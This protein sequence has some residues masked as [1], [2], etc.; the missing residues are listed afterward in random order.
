MIDL[1]GTPYGI[2]DDH[3]NFL[4]RTSDL[5]DR[6]NLLRGEGTLRPET[7][8]AYYG[9]KRFEEIS[10]SNAI[11]GSTLSVRETQLAVLSGVTITGHDPAYTRDA[12]NL[13]AALDR[14][15]ELAALDE[16][17][18]VSQLLQIHALVLGDRPGAGMFRS[19]RV[20]ISGSDHRPP[21]TWT[22]VMAA[23]EQWESWSAENTGVPTILRAVVLHTWLTHIHPFLDGNG[24]TARSVMNLEFIRSGYPS[25]ILRKRDRLR[26]YEALADS[27]AGG[28]LG[29][30]G[31]LIVERC[32]HA[33]A[34]LE[35]AARSAQGYSEVQLRLRQAQTRQMGIWNDAVRLLF[36]LVEDAL[37]QAF[38]GIGTVQ[39]KWYEAELQLDD[40]LAL[41]NE[42]PSGN[43][44]V[45][46]FEVAVP[47]LGRVSYLSWVGFRSPRMRT[48]QGIGSGP[49]L[50]WAV[51][52]PSGVKP[53]VQCEDV[54]PGGAELTLRVPDVDKWVVRHCNGDILRHQPS[55]LARQVVHDV[56]IALAGRG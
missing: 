3:S 24:R 38:G 9:D 52:D 27:D 48:W 13:A 37:Q 51:R 28:D 22:E 50:F 40:Y 41:L 26:Y 33:L 56:E 21:K 54:A 31:D 12:I 16:P 30:I 4:I 2:D 43:S 23:M 20:V 44:W 14:M 47:A 36:S 18:D 1:E 39:S 5:D 53:W 46:R 15:V 35:R 19:E 32:G 10:E 17:T 55:Q 29:A 6:V 11:E 45:F 49:S 34:A 25:V 42:D 8:R 7:L